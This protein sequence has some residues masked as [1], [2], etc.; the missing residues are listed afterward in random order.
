MSD[1]KLNTDLEKA[2]GP[3]SFTDHSCF[4]HYI[5]GSGLNIPV[6][7]FVKPTIT[8]IEIFT[9]TWN[10]LSDQNLVI[11]T[12]GSIYIAIVKVPD[13]I[14]IERGKTHLTRISYTI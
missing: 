2:L 1:T 13:S 14:S 10:D 3:K 9:G 8:K 11:R 7:S 5:Y 6:F 12:Y 4:G